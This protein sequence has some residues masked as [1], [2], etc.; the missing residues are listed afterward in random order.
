MSTTNLTNLAVVMLKQS[1]YSQTITYCNDALKI[2]HRNLKGLF[3]KGRCHMLMTDYNLAVQVFA[4]LLEI[5]PGHSEAQSM[6]KKT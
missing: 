6:L 4:E 5:D 1:N 2:D 3:L